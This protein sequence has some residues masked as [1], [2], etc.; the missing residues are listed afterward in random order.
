MSDHGGQKLYKQGPVEITGGGLIP[1][2]SPVNSH[3]VDRCLS[4]HEF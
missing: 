1:S 3:L 4:D 2:P